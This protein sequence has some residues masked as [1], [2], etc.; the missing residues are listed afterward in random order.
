MNGP[1][2]RISNASNAGLG[3]QR[4]VGKHR[5]LFYPPDLM[6]WYLAGPL[7]LEEAKAIDAFCAVFAPNAMQVEL[8]DGAVVETAVRKHWVE[9][10]TGL[11]VDR[12]TVVYGGTSSVRASMGLVL[13]AIE[14]AQEGVRRFP[15]IVTESEKEALIELTILRT[16]HARDSIVPM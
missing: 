10:D 13:T 14:G 12:P 6:R 4:L 16:K 9:T 15:V 5:V 2:R 3:A 11:A 7:N 8:G 1:P